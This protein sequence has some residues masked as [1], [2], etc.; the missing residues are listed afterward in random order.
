V[1]RPTTLVVV[2][3]LAAISLSG[4]GGADA[5]ADAD[6][7]HGSHSSHSPGQMTRDHKGVVRKGG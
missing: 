5:G 1:R 3:L 2:A 6:A 4:C 7:D